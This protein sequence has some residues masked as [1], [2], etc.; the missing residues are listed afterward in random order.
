MKIKA[1]KKI[2]LEKMKN[3]RDKHREVFLKAIDGFREEAVSLLEKGI[4]N[5]KKGKSV[6]LTIYL[7][8]P[9]D[10]TRD[11]NRIIGMIEMDERDVV[12]LTEGEFSQYILDDWRWKR[13]W[14]ETVSNY[15][16]AT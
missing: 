10:H 11:Y 14:V 12:E 13:E 6:D 2:I 16:Q 1:E 7:P 8:E 4:T 3:N 9:Q 15:T 5:L